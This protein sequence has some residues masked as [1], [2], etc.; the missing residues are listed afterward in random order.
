MRISGLQRGERGEGEIILVF[1]EPSLL[2]PD[3][4]N[5]EGGGK[6]RSPDRWWEASKLLV[7]GQFAVG[8]DNRQTPLLLSPRLPGSDREWLRMKAEVAQRLNGTCRSMLLIALLV[9]IQT[10]PS[11]IH[12]ATQRP[13]QPA[14]RQD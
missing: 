13:S 7:N 6:K 11:A 4:H 2:M 1:S 3:G 12:A 8:N 9:L 14:F 5:L 10:R